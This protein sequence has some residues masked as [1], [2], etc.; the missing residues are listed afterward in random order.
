MLLSKA[1]VVE[2]VVQTTNNSIGALATIPSFV[3]EKVHLP[4]YGFAIDTEI[5]VLPWCEEINRPGLQRIQQIVHLLGIIKGVVHFI[6]L[7]LCGVREAS[8]GGKNLPAVVKCVQTLSLHSL[9]VDL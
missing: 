8:G 6:S 4:K 3:S 5:C 2:K 1:V 9:Q 7:E